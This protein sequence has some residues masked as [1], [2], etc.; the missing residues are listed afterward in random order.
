MTEGFPKPGRRDGQEPCGEC[1]LQAG[2]T[3]DIC[4]AKHASSV[5]VEAAVE[6]AAIRIIRNRASDGPSADRAVAHAR[7]FDTYV[8]RDAKRDARAA[9]SGQSLLENGPAV[10]GGSTHD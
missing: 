9:L 2:E 10:L 7:Q 4:G 1:H 8:W 6:S 3:C 5:D